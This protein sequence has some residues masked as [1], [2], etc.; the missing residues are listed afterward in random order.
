MVPLHSPVGYRMYCRSAAV[1]SFLFTAYPVVTKLVE[2][3]LAQDWAHSALHVMSAIAAAYAGWFASSG[4]LAR[5]FTWGVAAVYGVL[6]VVGW[7]IDGLLLNTHLAIPLG[8]VD[9]VFHL[10]LAV[11]ATAAIVRAGQIRTA[12]EAVAG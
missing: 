10:A 8:P 3:Q 5:L 7:F 6:R 12:A 11:A 2:H 4:T 9:N 1:V